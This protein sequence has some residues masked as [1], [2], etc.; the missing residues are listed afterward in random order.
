[1]SKVA[2]V[3]ND[4]TNDCEKIEFFKRRQGLHDFKRFN[5]KSQDL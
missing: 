2:K 5:V 3:T 1:M 4:T